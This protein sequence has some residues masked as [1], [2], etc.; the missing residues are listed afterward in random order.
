MSIIGKLHI[1]A[2][3]NIEKEG[4]IVY[5]DGWLLRAVKVDRI[6][7]PIHDNIPLKNLSEIVILGR[8]KFYLSILEHCSALKKL[9]VIG[10]NI[11]DSTYVL[12]DCLESVTVRQTVLE[13]STLADLLS[14][15]PTTVKELSLDTI[16]IGTGDYFAEHDIESIS[17]LT[18]LE[19]LQIYRLSNTV[20]ECKDFDNL[21]DYPELQLPKDMSGLTALR[22][23]HVCHCNVTTIPD[24]LYTLTDLQ[25]IDMYANRLTD[26]SVLE[27]MCSLIGLKELILS[28]NQMSGP[29]PPVSAISKLADLQV[30]AISYNNIADVLTDEWVDAMPQIR[31][32]HICDNIYLTGTLDPDPYKDQIIQSVSMTQVRFEPQ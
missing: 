1:Y 32:L 7:N 6:Y 28:H 3:Y 25:R 8:I 21:G 10:A 11:M 4:E 23:L 12:N 24:S 15:L 22:Y 30:L 20:R 29:L 26:T 19:S 18:N 27:K 17:R 14:T 31:E 2:D 5:K 9:S 16:G 13:N